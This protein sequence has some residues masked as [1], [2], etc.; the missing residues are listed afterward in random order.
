MSGFFM[1][2]SV[3]ELLFNS[4]SFSISISSVQERIKL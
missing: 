4:P 3:L 1:F 2:I